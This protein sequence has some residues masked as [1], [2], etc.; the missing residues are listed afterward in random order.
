MNIPM[1]GKNSKGMGTVD[2]ARKIEMGEMLLE[3]MKM[4]KKNKPWQL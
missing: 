1:K 4:K 3:V 2:T